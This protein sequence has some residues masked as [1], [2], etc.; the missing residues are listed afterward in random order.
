MCDED[1]A[2]LVIDNGS[3]MCKAGFAGD[4]APRAVFPSIVGRP[5]HQGVMVGMGQKDSYVGDEAQSKRGI[6]TLK[7]PI[8]HGIVTN[9]DDMEKIWHHTFYNELRVAP[10]EHPVLLTEAPLNPKANREKMTQIMFETFNTPAM[11]V[12]IQ[13]VLSLY[14]SGRTTGIV[15]DSGD[16]VS[17]TVPIYEG[18]ALPHAILR[19]DLAGRDL[20]DYLMKILTER[21]Y[22]FTTTAERE[23]V[24]D[25]KEKLCYVA[26][27][28]EQEMHT[29]ASSSSLEKSYELPDGQVIT[30]G[31][32]RFRCPEAMFQPS[33]LGME[34]AG[35]HETTYNSIMKCDV[36]IRKDLYANTVLS[37]GSTMFPGIADRM[38]KEISGLAPSTMKI[39]IIA[40]PE[41]KYS[42]WIGGSILASLS[43]FQQMWI[44]KQEY[45]ESGP[46]IVHRKCNRGFTTENLKM[47]D[48]DVAALVVDNGSGMCKAGFAGDDAPRAVF[49][50]IVGRPRHQG[51]MVGM[52]QKDSYVGDEAQSKRGILTLKYPIEHGIVT[53][54]DDMEKIWHHTFYNELRVAP[55]EHPV[56]LTEAP[57]NPK[58][59]REKMTQ[60][61]FETFNSPAMYVAIQAVLSLYASG[62]T[63]GIVLDSGD[64]VSHTVP[65]YE[66]YALPHAIIRLDLA[67][68]DLTDYL[69]KIL[70]ERGYSFTTTAEREIVRDIKEKLSYVALDFEQEMQTAASSSSLEKSYELPD[71]QVITIGN[72]RF[73]CPETLFQ[74]SFIGMESAG[75]HETTYNSIMKCDVDI[76]KDLYANTVLSGGTTMF[77][78]IA[79]RMQKEISALAPPTMKIKIIAPP[80]RK[81]SVW[82]GGSILASLSTFQQMWISKQEYDESGPSIVHRKCF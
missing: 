69:M 47:C 39:K 2:A 30:I 81:Y 31:N 13:A 22:S 7:Y 65:I 70:T 26:L 60:I 71:G 62:R 76:R 17:H 14:A 63:T 49:P 34:S 57:L 6:L 5:R 67:G 35:I 46:S 82:I 79:D 23:I 75:V 59:N 41:R 12:A 27:D 74:P 10:E 68:R 20:T 52:G 54:W 80:E 19:L 66:G 36:D 3:G 24:R 11:Y 16:G 58:A 32:E 77:P 38:Q 4:D 33:F 1:I 8:E 64:G 42:V 48:E 28:F 53:N 78:G 61:M 56:L 43:T 72:E 55:E 51:V 73:R 18:Y 9:W 37:G 21:G 45:D 40:P 44:S 29:A 50:S 25:I 15:L